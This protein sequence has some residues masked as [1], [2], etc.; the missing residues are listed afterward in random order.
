[1][2]AVGGGFGLNNLTAKDVTLTIDGV[3][4]HLRVNDQTVAGVL[5]D[6][7]VTLGSHDLVSPSVSS[8]VKEGQEIEVRYGREITAVVD[9]VPTTFWTTARTVEDALAQLDV[10]HN[11]KLSTS[12]STPIGRQGLDFAIDTFVKVKIVAG[13]KTQTI[14]AAGT[15]KDALAQAGITTDSDDKVS[16]TL[17][18]D[19]VEGMTITVVKV[20]TTTSTRTVPIKYSTKTTKSGSLDQ[21]VTQVKVKGVDGSKT[22]TVV[23]R[24]E[25]GKQVSSTVTASKV[26]KQPVQEVKVVGT[27][28][29]SS[30]SSSSSGSASNVSPATG[31][32]CQASYYWEGQMTASGEQFNPNDLTA[33]HKT[34]PLGTR[35]KVTNPSNGKTV[36]VRI[37]D[38]GPYVGGRCLDLSRAAMEAI[39]GT[40]AGVITVNW[41]T[42]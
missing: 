29:T 21:G 2:L 37:N 19:L 26:T 31:N 35:I 27:R 3:S 4:Q 32:T 30:S 20:Q 25:D 41:A 24:V 18:D 36:V 34:L 17:S 15:V 1:M 6:H 14:D 7:G 42:V 39:G 13:G 9:G 38:R 10:R 28:A 23:I 8:G 22:E 5:L 40:S 12:R 33:A 11:I 16:K